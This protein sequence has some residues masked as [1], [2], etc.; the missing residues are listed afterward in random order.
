MQ[1]IGIKDWFEWC[2]RRNID[3]STARFA[4]ETCYYGRSLLRSRPGALL[5]TEEAILHDSYGVGTTLWAIGERETRVEI[6]LRSILRLRRRPVG[7][8][9]KLGWFYPEAHYQIQTAAGPNHD[10]ILHRDAAAFEAVLAEAGLI[11]S[12]EEL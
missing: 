4:V 12:H 7:W 5:V 3:P 10:L 9:L 8:L 11:V 6:P 1:V 2:S